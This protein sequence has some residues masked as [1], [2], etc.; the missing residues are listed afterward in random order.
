MMHNYCNMWYRSLWRVFI[1]ML[2][3]ATTL[4][5]M[6][7]AALRALLLQGRQ[8]VPVGLYWP[9]SAKP[10]SSAMLIVDTPSCQI[11]DVHAYDPGISRSLRY[12]KSHFVTCKHSKP[13]TFTDRQYIR[14]NTTLAKSLNIAQCH[15]QQVSRDVQAALI[16]TI[17]YGR[18]VQLRMLAEPVTR[19]FSFAVDVLASSPF[20]FCAFSPRLIM[21]VAWPIKQASK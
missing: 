18:Q 8:H 17:F 2:L 6:Q 1:A 5:M 13:I 10:R 9:S 21:K 4:L 12:P 19:P 7:S 3:I 20:I 16:G 15:Y 14:L 11:L